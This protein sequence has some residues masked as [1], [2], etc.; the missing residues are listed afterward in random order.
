MTGFIFA[1]KFDHLDVVKF[2]L[3]KFSKVVN[4]IDNQNKGGYDYLP[5]ESSFNIRL[6]IE[7]NNLNLKKPRINLSKIIST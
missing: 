3:E 1:C 7:E 5:I 4:Q 2:F 6:Y